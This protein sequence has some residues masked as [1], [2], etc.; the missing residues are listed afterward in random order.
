[1]NN[2]DE[3]SS[4]LSVDLGAL[5][6][7]LESE[8]LAELVDGLA[9]F[10]DRFGFRRNLG[11]LW[12][13]LYLSPQPLTQAEL[14]ELLGLS[15]GLIS[16]GLKELEHYGAVRVVM[17]RGSR[18]THYEAE[19]RLLRIVAAILTRRELPSV[20]KLRETVRNVRLEYAPD[21]LRDTS[22]PQRFERRLDA[23]ERLCDLYDALTGLIARISRLPS[24][25]IENT[26]RVVGAAR[27]LESE[28]SAAANA[29]SRE[30]RERSA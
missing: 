12:A 14:G 13:A 11:R 16:S 15:A 24:V 22:W 1:M 23:I 8:P 9:R 27:F 10:F 6:A 25:A 21:A 7:Q 19:E 3:I 28:A 4:D 5:G 26:M 30:P 18:A 2:K 20:R 17:L 29:T